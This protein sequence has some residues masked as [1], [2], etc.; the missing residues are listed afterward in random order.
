ME[1]LCNWNSFVGPSY[2]R[3]QQ[4]RW[5]AKSAVHSA[6]LE[7]RLQ[8]E[9]QADTTESPPKQTASSADSTESSQSPA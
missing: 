5:F 1:M 8:L 4:Q 9:N 6:G 2:L 3:N 7:S